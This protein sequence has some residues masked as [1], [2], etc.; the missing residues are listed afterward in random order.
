MAAEAPARQPAGGAEPGWYVDHR[1]Y[2]AF[3]WTL[4]TFL[5][6]YFRLHMTGMSNVPRTGPAV[7]VSNHQSWLDP[8]LLAVK[9]PRIVA[10]MAKAEWFTQPAA[11]H[12]LREIGVFPVQRGEADA[13]AIKLALQVLREG[14]LLGMFPEGTRSPSGE[15]QLMRAGAVRIAEKMDVPIVPACVVG[16]ARLMPKGALFPRPGV[17]QIRYGSPYR[18]SDLYGPRL[19][20]A[21]RQAAVADMRARIVALMDSA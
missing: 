8:W 17:I 3:R 20:Q 13:R 5:R 16:S 21:Q 18:L 14:E 4:G 2:T 6:T 19:T 12:V 1:W 11:N 15:L 10:F 7:L 9:L